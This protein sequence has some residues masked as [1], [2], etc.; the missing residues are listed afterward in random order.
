MATGDSLLVLRAGDGTPTATVSAGLTSIA[1][2]STPAERFTVAAFDDTT[3]EYWDFPDLIMPRHF[4]G[5][6]GITLNFKTSAAAATNSFVL[7]ASLRRVADDAEVVT[8]AH[9]Y[10]YQDTASITAPSG[11]GEYTYDDLAFTNAQMDGVVA[12]D[13]F[14]LRVS[15]SSGTITGDVYLH[16]IEIRET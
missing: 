9:T 7:S 16:T 8:A 10:V 15:V 2:G 11:V 3:P 1:G 14:V 12:A 6:T 13:S 5:T 4:A